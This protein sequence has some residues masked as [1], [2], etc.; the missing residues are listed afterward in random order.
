MTVRSIPRAIRSAGVP[1]VLATLLSGC[2][3]PLIA[4]LTLG[5]VGLFGSLF[6]T[7][8]TGKGLG[9]HAMDAATGQDCR[10]L[11]GLAR[12]DRDLCE[13]DG[14]PATEKDWKGLASL[15]DETLP[16]VAP[17]PGSENRDGRDG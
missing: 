13:R 16:S 7:A 6:S 4:G 5:E 1:F 8:A 15:S 14:S 10:V 3:T 17:I 2:S 12:D 11:E 9:E